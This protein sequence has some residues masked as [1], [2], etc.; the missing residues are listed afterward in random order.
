MKQL[1]DKNVQIVLAGGAIVVCTIGLLTPG[2]YGVIGTSIGLGLAAIS[3]WL[4]FLEDL[5][6]KKRLVFGGLWT[7]LV[8]GFYF[9][10]ATLNAAFGFLAAFVATFVVIALM[11]RALTRK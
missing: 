9:A 11:A 3:S 5:G 6:A 1:S 7:V 4:G 10:V 2:T 8:T